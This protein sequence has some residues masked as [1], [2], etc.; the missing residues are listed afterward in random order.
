MQI[1]NFNFNGLSA[2]KAALKI[3]NYFLRA[4]FRWWF[5]ALLVETEADDNDSNPKVLIT[6]TTLP[7]FSFSAVVWNSRG[8]S[9]KFAHEC[10]Q[11]FIIIICC[12]NFDYGLRC[13]FTSV[14]NEHR[15]VN[16]DAI[17]ARK[18]KENPSK[19]ALPMQDF[20]TLPYQTFRFEILGWQRCNYCRK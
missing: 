6:S 13:F 2:L 17:K 16:L 12:G 18:L 19:S 8:V 11:K 10:Q 14:F 20:K 5:F 1:L 3:V 15:L 7:F 4:Q 9:G